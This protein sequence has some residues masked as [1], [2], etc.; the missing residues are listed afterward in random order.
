MA[1]R[2]VF[3]V[4]TEDNFSVRAEDI[5]FKWFPGMSLSQR[6]HSARSLAESVQ[7]KYPEK[8]ILEVSRMSDNALGVKLSAFNL[9]YPAGNKTAGKPVECVFQS[10]KVFR[11]GGPYRDLITKSPKDAKTDPRL[12]TSGPLLEFDIEGEKWS[13]Q[14]LTAFYDW[15]YMLALRA[16]PKLADDVSNYDVF[17]DIAFNPQKSFNC[18]AQTVALFVSLCKK[19]IVDQVLNSRETYLAYLNTDKDRVAGNANQMNLGL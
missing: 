16:Y 2:P 9:V 8:K 4:S 7:K 14:P 11:D 10:S 17:T 19:N 15:I 6:Q 18:Q 3:F 13:N 12:K 1:V 5:D